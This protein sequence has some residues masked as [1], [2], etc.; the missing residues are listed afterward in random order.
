VLVRALGRVQAESGPVVRAEP[1]HYVPQWPPIRLE[2]GPPLKFLL[3]TENEYQALMRRRER[4]LTREIRKL[5]SRC[6]CHSSLHPP[7][8]CGQPAAW[9]WHFRPEHVYPGEPGYI[10]LCGDC[11]A[12]WEG[13]HLTPERVDARPR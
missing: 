6:A 2:D 5:A 10:G 12:E 9:T 13:H 11:R 1:E 3:V 7:T 4:V 8:G